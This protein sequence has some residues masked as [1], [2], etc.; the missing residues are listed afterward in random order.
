M[1]LQSI[2]LRYQDQIHSM[3]MACKQEISELNSLLYEANGKIVEQRREYRAVVQQRNHFESKVMELEGDLEDA[4][5]FAACDNSSASASEAS[6]VPIPNNGPVQL[7]AQLSEARGKVESLMQKQAEMEQTLSLAEEAKQSL[8]DASR[9]LQKDVQEAEIRDKGRREKIALLT[10]EESKHK[11]LLELQRK[12][13]ERSEE[14][15]KAQAQRLSDTRRELDQARE[16][17]KQLQSDLETAMAKADDQKKELEAVMEKAAAQQNDLES[18]RS[19]EKSNLEQSKEA[20][21]N[22]NR[23]LLSRV[24]DGAVALEKAQKEKKLAQA[25]YEKEARQEA[26]RVH[27]IESQFRQISDAH[28]AKIS[29]LENKCDDLSSMLSNSNVRVIELE[30]ALSNTPKGMVSVDRA[31]ALHNENQRLRNEF[32]KIQSMKS[33]SD[34]QLLMAE[35]ALENMTLEVTNLKNLRVE[36]EET[37]AQVTAMK[38]ESDEIET[39]RKEVEA[40]SK[41]AAEEM[42][43][44]E[45][46]IK[47]RLAALEE[48]EEKASQR[49]AQAQT[50]KVQLTRAITRIRELNSYNSALETEVATG[51]CNLNTANHVQVIVLRHLFSLHHKNDKRF[52]A[53]LEAI[54]Y[55]LKVTVGRSDRATKEFIDRLRSQCM[56]HGGE[57]PSSPLPG[58]K[59]HKKWVELMAEIGPAL[60]DMPLPECA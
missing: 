32:S 36:L 54:K 22:E 15:A 13:M 23:E 9:Q 33:E 44:K 51:L 14:T 57:T 55:E 8:M 1:D 49:N 19:A 40:M 28:T 21:R 12:A 2:H 47:Q 25:K 7:M 30:T 10:L 16:T 4:G 39:A 52:E 18:F 41:N 53:M 11:S 38:A 45:D 50:S 60:E 29:S 24:K 42:K 43:R 58:P 6:T 48:E 59:P 17:N 20:L 56:N 26:A 34:E 31:N 27:A 35:A 5:S 37:Q 46:G 3:S